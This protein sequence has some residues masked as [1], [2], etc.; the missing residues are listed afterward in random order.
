MRGHALIGEG[1][2]EGYERML[3]GDIKVLEVG[4]WL[5][6]LPMSFSAP[7][8]CT[9]GPLRLAVLVCWRAVCVCGC[10]KTVSLLDGALAG[11]SLQGPAQC[12]R[13]GNV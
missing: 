10:T 9:V 13:E 5:K 2:G 1:E 6:R 3:N 8:S 4:G 11:H 12:L 7:Q